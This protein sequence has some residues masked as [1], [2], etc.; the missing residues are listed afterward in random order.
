MIA[1]A[2]KLKWIENEVI[3]RQRRYAKW[4]AGG[5]MT[6]EAAVKEIATMAAIQIDYAAIVAQERAQ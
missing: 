4:V 5:S 6:E 2:D 1:A 3:Q